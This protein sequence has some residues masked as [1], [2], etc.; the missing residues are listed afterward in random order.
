[1]KGNRAVTSKTLSISLL[2]LVALS[3]CGEKDII[4]PGMREPIRAEATQVNR[5]LPISFAA[6]VA[7]AN[8]THRNGGADHNSPQPA[9]AASLSSPTPLSNTPWLFPTPR[10]LNRRVAKPRRWKVL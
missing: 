2:A 3:A 6:P 7:N 1:M 5:A 9:L 10:K 4:L 8:W